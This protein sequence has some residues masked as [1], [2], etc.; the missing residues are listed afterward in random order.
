MPRVWALAGS[1]SAQTAHFTPCTESAVPEWH[2]SE[3]AGE[4]REVAE[5]LT[6]PW[7]KMD[8]PSAFMDA[9]I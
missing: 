9:L 3:V 7:P 5:S 2:A 8:F 4:E 1:V 6:H